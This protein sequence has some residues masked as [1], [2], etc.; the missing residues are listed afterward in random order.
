MA[1]LNGEGYFHVAKNRNLP[2][3]VNAGGIEIKVLGTKFNVSAYEKDDMFK[4]T[5]SQGS[6]SIKTTE[7]E[8]V[9]IPG[10]QALVKKGSN[11]ILV[12]KV[13]PEVT[14]IWQ[15]EK[16]QFRNASLEEVIR[17]LESWYHV[18]FTVDDHLLQAERFTMTIKNE[19]LTQVLER[20]KITTELDYKINGNQV[21]I[22]ANIK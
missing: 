1:K 20:M 15:K 16:L 5:L 4:T 21:E 2:F 14:F 8:V 10:Q 17:K 19:S 7:E 12:D 3:V 22:K 9:L 13:D 11:Q 18:S 6:V